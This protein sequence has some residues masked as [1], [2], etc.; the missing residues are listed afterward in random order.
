M[1]SRE[2]TIW[3]DSIPTRPNYPSNK[4]TKYLIYR[5]GSNAANQRM[6]QT[7]PLA[8]IEAENKLKARV[9][10]EDYHTFYSNQSSEA[11][12]ESHASAK[13][14]NQVLIDNNCDHEDCIKHEQVIASVEAKY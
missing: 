11:I 14:W 2:L 12:A 4:M 9:I 1:R 8:I 6:C 10:A 3:R 13:D 7:M 5:H